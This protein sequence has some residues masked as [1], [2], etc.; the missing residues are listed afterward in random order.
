MSNCL[1]SFTI[2]KFKFV[3]SATLGKKR[4]LFEARTKCFYRI[5]KKTNTQETFII[6]FSPEKLARLL[7][8]KDQ[9]KSSPDLQMV[10]PLTFENLFNFRHWDIKTQKTSS[11][12]T[13]ANRFSRQNAWHWFK[14]THYLVLRKSNTSIH[15]VVLVLDQESKAL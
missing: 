11:Q 2:S 9:V 12:M 5:R 10:K 4:H 6:R 8:L 1:F 7:L 14:R 15:I 13:T 3:C